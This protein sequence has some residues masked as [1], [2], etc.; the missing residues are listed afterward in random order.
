VLLLF[1]TFGLNLVS[2]YFLA[3]AKKA[4]GRS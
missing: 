4:A 3:R 2:E 1:L